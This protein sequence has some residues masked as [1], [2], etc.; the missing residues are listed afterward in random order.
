MTLDVA[1][2]LAKGVVAGG[3]E[4]S[5]A[6]LHTVADTVCQA[7][8]RLEN[9]REKESTMS[10]WTARDIPSQTNRVAIVTGPTAASALKPSR[11][12]PPKVPGS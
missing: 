9:V 4:L 7:V 11:R 5:E 3:L 12:S 6:T 10:H 8:L 2:S 1:V